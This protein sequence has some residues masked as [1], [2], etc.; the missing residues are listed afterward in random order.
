MRSDCVP[1][2]TSICRTLDSEAS[3]PVGEIYMIN[4]LFF[5]FFL[6]LYH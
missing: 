1:D 3:Q 6:F 2:P 4:L 5:L